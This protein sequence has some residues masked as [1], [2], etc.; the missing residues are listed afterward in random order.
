MQVTIEC[1]W[2]PVGAVGRT[3]TGRLRF[4]AAPTTPGVYCFQVI[5]A[6]GTVVYIGESQNLH[7][8]M[9]QNYASTHTGATNVR[10]REWLQSHLASGQEVTMLVVTTARLC[11]DGAWQDADLS[12]RHIR[13]LVENAALAQA[14]ACRVLVSNA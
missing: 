7:H 10:I 2:T 1:N 12:Q 9:T 8:R 6:A 5:T 14:H 4:P 13:I 3:L 11:I